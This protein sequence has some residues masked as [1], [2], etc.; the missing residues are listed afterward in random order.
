VLQPENTDTISEYYAES[1]TKDATGSARDLDA[2]D[3]AAFRAASSV[4]SMLRM[5]I[6]DDSDVNS[7]FGLGRL[8]FSISYDFNKR[9]LNVNIDEA[10]NLPAK[11]LNGTSDPYVKVTG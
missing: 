6:T 7:S 1:P 9:S 4:E 3:T 11:D 8:H 5:A 2:V 10:E